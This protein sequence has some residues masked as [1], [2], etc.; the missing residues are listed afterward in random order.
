LSSFSEKPGRSDARRNAERILDAAAELLATN[1][2]VSLEQM[3]ARA[4]V[5]RATLYHHFAGRDALLDALTARSVLEVTAA[6]E[7]ARPDEGSA[8]EAV[9]RVLRAAWQVMGRYRGLVI[10][11]PRR[12]DRAELRARL[13]PAL[14]PIR[15]LIRRGQSSGEIDPELPA[16]WLI[17]VITDLMHAASG[18]VTVG[19]MDA[20]SAERVLLRTARGALAG[21]SAPPSPAHPAP[22]LRQRRRA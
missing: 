2:G 22:P 15:R 14:G 9:D 6:V 12:L 3:A 19:A 13:E 10:V 1:P 4:G 5:S 18:Q 20:D 7:A 11:N 16:E 21:P 17:G 8:S